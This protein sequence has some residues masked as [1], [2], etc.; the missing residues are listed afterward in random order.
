MS[1]ITFQGGKETAC[2]R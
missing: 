2:R 1:S